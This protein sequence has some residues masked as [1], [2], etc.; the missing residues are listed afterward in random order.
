MLLATQRGSLRHVN[1]LLR[2]S[3]GETGVMDFGLNCC[4]ILLKL[5]LTY[6]IIFDDLLVSVLM[7]AAAECE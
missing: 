3:Y 4:L 5:S 7:S 6:L 2:G 1:D